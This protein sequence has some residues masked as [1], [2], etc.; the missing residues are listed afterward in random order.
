MATADECF[1]C[2]KLDASNKK[3][4]SMIEC[5]T[6]HSKFRI[7]C[8]E[9]DVLFTALVAINDARCNLLPDPMENRTWLLAAYRQFHGY[10]G[11]KNR[12]VIPACAVKAIRMESPEESVNMPDLNRQKLILVQIA[13]GLN[14]N[15]IFPSKKAVIIGDELMKQG[16]WK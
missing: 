4:K 6:K 7:V 15:K 3:F 2:Q 5:I 8:V 10:L 9:H 12:R 16:V 13:N 11:R 1:C 14:Q